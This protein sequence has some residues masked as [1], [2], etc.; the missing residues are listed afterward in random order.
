MRPHDYSRIYPREKQTL[1]NRNV[2]S[3]EGL[4]PM[5]EGINQDI[6][7]ITK[8][9]RKRSL[10]VEVGPSNV[11]QSSDIRFYSTI[12]CCSIQTQHSIFL[13]RTLLWTKMSF[14]KKQQPR[15]QNYRHL[16]GI[17]KNDKNFF[18]EVRSGL[19]FLVLYSSSVDFRRQSS[20]NNVLMNSNQITLA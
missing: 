20:K 18:L 12:P 5:Y 8:I 16:D 17:S 14:I 7:W 9:K 19:C 4:D 2:Y 15:R 13:R 6:K 10:K 11:S 1:C 3:C